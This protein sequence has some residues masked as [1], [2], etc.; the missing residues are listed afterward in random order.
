MAKSLVSCFFLT[1]RVDALPINNNLNN[2]CLL[3]LNS[4][5]NIFYFQPRNLEIL[6]FVCTVC[7]YYSYAFVCKGF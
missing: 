6:L 7:M 3:F 2:D 5:L 1:H 4:T